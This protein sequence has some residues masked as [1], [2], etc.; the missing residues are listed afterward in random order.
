[1]SRAI[2]HNGTRAQNFRKA[3]QLS[4]CGAAQELTGLHPERHGCQ[5]DGQKAEADGGEQPHEPPRLPLDVLCVLP[6]GDE[7]GQR[8][9][10]RPRAADVHAHQ[11]PLIV[12][13]EPAQQDGR[14]H[15][16]DDLT[17]Q[18][19]HRHDPVGQQLAE[20]L[21]HRLDPRHVA[22]EGEERR[23]CHQQSPVHA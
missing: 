17:G 14:R 23:E 20:Q 9:H 5:Q 6:E 19:R 15:V 7:A 1:M 16:A 18:R 12:I 3:P 21:T 10:Q 2:P 22:G 11:Q 4:L 13:G 8:R